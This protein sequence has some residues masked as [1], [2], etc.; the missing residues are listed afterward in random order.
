VVRRANRPVTH[1]DERT[2]RGR[3]RTIARAVLLS[4]CSRVVRTP[5]AVV[6][7]IGCREPGLGTE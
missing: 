1:R 5:L 3:H 6:D 2:A 4:A 7:G